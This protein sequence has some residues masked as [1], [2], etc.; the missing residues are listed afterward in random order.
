MNKCLQSLLLPILLLAQSSTFA[1][2][3]Q[4]WI[5][6]VSL[7]LGTDDDSNNTHVYRVGFQNKWE[8]SWFH[9][10]AWYL[11]GYWDT[12][13]GYLESD[14]GSKGELV[15]VSVTPILRYQRDADISSGVSPFAEA[16][17]G[18]HL[19][20]ENRIGN[21]NL[22]TALQYGSIVGVGVG[23]GERGQYELAYRFQHISN[24]DTNDANDGINLHLL[25]LGYNFY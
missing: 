19:I 18:A 17:L 23:F 8:R 16:G 5:D 12:E 7:S 25:R 14:L 6:S 15:D 10:G 1:A 21:L 2:S 9:G 4:R 24:A 11:S 20:S 3:E 22:G 13:L